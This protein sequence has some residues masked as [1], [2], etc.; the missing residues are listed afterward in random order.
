MT[1]LKK[2]HPLIAASALFCSFG[3]WSADATLMSRS[4]YNEQNDK[5]EAQYQQDK[6]SCSVQSGNAKDVCDKQAKGREKIAKAQ[7]DYDRTGK[8]SDRNKIEKTKAD[9]DFSVAQERCD[10]AK[11]NAHELCETQAKTAHTKALSSAKMS[12]KIDDARSDARDTDNDANWKM[13]KERCDT[14]SGSAKT[15]CMDDAK[16]RYHK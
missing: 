1:P 3:A 2:L 9:V 8:A 4:S 16:T 5:I 10:D 14:A 6:Q 12:K 11:G 15:Q 13:A 7:L